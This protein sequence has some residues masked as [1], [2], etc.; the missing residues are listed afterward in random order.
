VDF[1]LEV[2]QQHNTWYEFLATRSGT[3]TLPWLDTGMKVL[4]WESRNQNNLRFGYSI[5]LFFLFGSLILFCFA[6]ELVICFFMPM[7][8]DLKTSEK[9]LVA[10]L[11]FG[12]IK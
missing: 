4:V 9:Y 7:C 5:S 6:I 8:E 12:F 2:V 3:L 11:M 1:L 10:Q